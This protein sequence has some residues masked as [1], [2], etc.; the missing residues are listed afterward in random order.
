MANRTFIQEIIMKHAKPQKTRIAAYGL[1]QDEGRLLLCRISRQLPK[2]AGMWTL[3]GGGLDFG[4][5]PSEAM[6]REVFEETGLSVRPTSLAGIDS[7]HDKTPEMAFHSIRII[8]YAEIVGGELR[9]EHDG[10]TDLCAWHT[11][12]N[13]DQLELVDLVQAALPMI[14]S[15]SDSEP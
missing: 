1:I 6:V 14:S 10:T 8:Y 9:N 7:I 2:H 15:L 5:A 3:P 11:Q 4:E 12:E 13:I